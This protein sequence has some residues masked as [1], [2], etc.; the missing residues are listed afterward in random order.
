M[1]LGESTRD[2]TER[3]NDD[4]N[5]NGNNSINDYDININKGGGECNATC[6][7]EGV[8]ACGSKTNVS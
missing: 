8:G 3:P 2:R 1:K 4:D 6:V 5:N 7:Q